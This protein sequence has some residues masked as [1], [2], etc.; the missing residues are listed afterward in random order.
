MPMTRVRRLLFLA[1]SLVLGCKRDEPSTIPGPGAKSEPEQDASEPER[2][3]SIGVV[4]E[5]ELEPDPAQLEAGV[6]YL[7]FHIEIGDS[8]SRG[9]VDAPVT[10]VMFSDFECP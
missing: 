3:K 7:R 10:I 4:T 6:P 9:P 1:A 5:G 2:D 8:P